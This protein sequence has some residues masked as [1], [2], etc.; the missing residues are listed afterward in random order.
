MSASALIL[1]VAQ[2]NGKLTTWEW[3]T[4]TYRWKQTLE[5]SFSINR[6]AKAV[7][8]VNTTKASKF[9]FLLKLIFFR[10]LSDLVGEG[11]II[12]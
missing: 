11:K 6:V 12:H 7:F 10:L 3:N 8:A 4:K 9:C 2:A 5:I 1:C